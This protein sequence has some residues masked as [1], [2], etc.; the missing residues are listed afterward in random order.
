MNRREFLHAAA[1]STIVIVTGC[2]RQ[3]GG[4][5]LSP[6]E[7]QRTTTVQTTEGI[8]ARAEDVPYDELYRRISDYKG[9]DVHFRGSVASFFEQSEGYQE[10]IIVL[11]GSSPQEAIENDE[12]YRQ[13]AVVG[14]W[15]GDLF[16]E[17]DDVEFWGTVLGLRT[18]M[19]MTGEKTLP[20][21]EI[22]EM[23]LV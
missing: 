11:E 8:R 18:Y 5:N 19:S 23:D 17:G 9:E 22:V 20:E 14:I 21:I 15:R 16:R 4:S 2:S 3:G 10:M 1:S 6:D 12:P 13:E 7:A